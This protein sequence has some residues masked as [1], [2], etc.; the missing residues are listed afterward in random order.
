MSL[1]KIEVYNSSHS[2]TD[3]IRFV[4]GCLSGIFAFMDR[5]VFFEGER[6]V[7]PQALIPSGILRK[8][9][10][11]YPLS[12]EL[13][14]GVFGQ[15]G[16]DARKGGVNYCHIS[17]M[18]AKASGLT[19]AASYAEGGCRFTG[20]E[21]IH[22]KIEKLIVGIRKDNYI[23]S[24]KELMMHVTNIMIMDP[25]APSYATRY[26]DLLVF[27]F[28]ELKKDTKDDELL[29]R[30]FT[31]YIG[32]IASKFR[33]ENIPFKADE[34]FMNEVL[35]QF[36]IIICSNICPQGFS[37]GVSGERLSFSSADYYFDLISEIGDSPERGVVYVAI[38]PPND[39]KYIVKGI[40][41]EVI[42]DS[43]PLST[44]GCNL[45]MLRDESDLETYFPNILSE[46]LKRG[47]TSNG[48][49]NFSTVK[50]IFV[51]QTHVDQLRSILAAHGL[52]GIHVEEC[53]FLRSDNFSCSLST[54][55]VSHCR[56]VQTRFKNEIQTHAASESWSE[57]PTPKSSST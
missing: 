32:Y 31:K 7:V 42:S 53:E 25:H 5:E 21:S 17:G 45:G 37:G 40:S 33:D 30:I 47:H 36:P 2:K 43:I 1:E 35:N 51:A 57:L 48:E 44:I 22:E 4:H 38:E 20:I 10:G 13:G 19:V 6:K 16:I 14:R 26:I 27:K 50:M 15:E 8:K 11:L 46:T 34:R 55:D 56:A 12:G 41:G 23:R 39:L 3:K 29:S 52:T 28:N 9:Y 24:L 49:I 18:D 54:M